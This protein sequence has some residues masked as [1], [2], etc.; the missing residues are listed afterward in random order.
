ML[1]ILVEIIMS[2]FIAN[3]KASEHPIISAVA[4]GI[5]IMATIFFMGLF[6]TFF[7]GNEFSLKFA[8]IVSFVLGLLGSILL[9]LIEVFFNYV[10]RRK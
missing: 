7:N 6:S 9:F 3:F 5:L 4:R 1:T 10:D 8:L 2:V